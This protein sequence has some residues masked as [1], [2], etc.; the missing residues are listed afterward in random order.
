MG[1]RIMCRVVYIRCILGKII[2]RKDMY[3]F[4]PLDKRHG[5]KIER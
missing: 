3:M 2:A 5:I 4:L 1:W